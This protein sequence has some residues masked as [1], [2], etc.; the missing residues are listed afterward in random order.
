MASALERYRCAEM[1]VPENDQLKVRCVRRLLYA[2][3]RRSYS[4]A[5]R[6]F[7]IEW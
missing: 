7:E 4:P 6:S 5:R 3:C 1:Y 2:V